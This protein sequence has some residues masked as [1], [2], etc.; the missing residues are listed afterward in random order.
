MSMSFGFFKQFTQRVWGLRPFCSRG[1]AEYP[2]IGPSEVSK[3]TLNNVGWQLVQSLSEEAMEMPVDYISFEPSNLTE[4]L[5]KS[6]TILSSI[7]G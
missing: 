3:S 5:F 1:G 2:F 7:L 6:K 4:V